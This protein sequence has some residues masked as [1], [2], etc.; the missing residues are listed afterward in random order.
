MSEPRDR[1][2]FLSFAIAGS[3]YGVP[4]LRVKEILQYEAITPVPAAP[5]SIRGVINLRGAVV[6]VVDLA[7]KFGLP[8]T[9]VTN[10]TCILIVEAGLDSE[11]S[12]VGV[13]ADAVS[14]V[15]ELSPDDL[16]PP[17]TLGAH[18]QLEYLA[19]M[20]KVG[21]GFV[22]LLDLDRVLSAAEKELGARPPPAEAI[23]APPDAGR[24]NTPQN[25]CR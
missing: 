20:G 7:V 17:P 3:D 11:R 18:I 12:V 21:K 1:R 14:E 19:G 4:I 8:V 23:P 22:L 5:R 13:L 15:L 2:Q 25:H 24:T 9:P 10:R 16:E 6:P